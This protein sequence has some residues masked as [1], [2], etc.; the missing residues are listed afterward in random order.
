MFDYKGTKENV[1]V[2]LGLLNQASEQLLLAEET[3][4]ENYKEY[5][6]REVSLVER[7]FK[8][9][10]QEIRDILI[11][12]NKIGGDASISS[13]SREVKISTSRAKK[14][15]DE[16]YQQLLITADRL[17]EKYPIYFEE[18]VNKIIT[19]LVKILGE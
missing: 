13:T 12:E 18:E 17:A 5:H 10:I 2:M 3:L 1:E 14:H 4:K 7:E 19:Q 9:K 6:E 11:S 16:I 8:K 15:F